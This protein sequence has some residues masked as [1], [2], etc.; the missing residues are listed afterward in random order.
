MKRETTANL[1]DGLLDGAI[2]LFIEKGVENVTTR[3]LTDLM[4]ISRSH[5]YHYFK[6]WQALRLAACSHFM[7]AEL[8]EMA[9]EVENMPPQQALDRLIA[10]YLPVSMDATWVLYMDVWRL[11]G[12]DK[13]YSR[14]TAELIQ[15]WDRLME[16]AIL[17]GIQLGVFRPVDA[18][19]AARQL[20][21]LVNGYADTLMFITPLQTRD[22]VIDE[23]NQVV[24]LILG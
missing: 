16:K 23:I 20:A 7:Y 24:R 6:N 8:N 1:R 10:Q 17:D 13:E 9:R 19:R 22:E 21:A 15:A 12:Q 4:G 5:I 18:A 2:K 3:E 14:L 11:A